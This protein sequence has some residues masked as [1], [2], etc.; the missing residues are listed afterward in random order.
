MNI[1]EYAGG[2]NYTSK[3]RPSRLCPNAARKAFEGNTGTGLTPKYMLSRPHSEAHEGSDHD[4]H[5]CSPPTR[6][7]GNEP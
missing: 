5:R 7:T 2:N 6:L 4:S 1:H 3:A